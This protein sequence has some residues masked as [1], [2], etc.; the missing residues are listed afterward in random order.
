MD[1]KI[2]RRTFLKFSAA[3]LAATAT[4]ATFKESRAADWQE[5][6]GK[7]G[8]QPD[9]VDK[10]VKRVRSTCLMCHSGCGITAK[11]VNGELVK[12]EG[13]PYNPNNYDYT[14][15]GDIVKENDL[16]TGPLGK[17]V[18]SLCAKGQSGIFDLYNPNR[19]THPLKRAGARGSGKW[20][21]ISWDQAITE[22]VEGGY[23]F[24]D[25]PGEE[26]RYV[27]GLR[28]IRNLKEDIGSA[29]SDFMDEAPPGGYGPK[30][31]QFVWVH[32]RNEQG[33]VT[34]RFIKDSFGSPN[35]FSH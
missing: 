33:A 25:V 19:I 23:L 28:K 8:S 5:Q 34:K 2:K 31:N 4:L 24:K 14:A 7:R 3:T 27:D 12:L 9:P 32:G 6:I 16:D 26:K 10:D 29:E 22:I 17:D 35:H 13:N 18:G 30:A 11:V 1:T 21:K 20:K 15:R